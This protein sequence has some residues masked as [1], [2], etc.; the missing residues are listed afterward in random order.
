MNDDTS[1]DGFESTATRR[2]VLAGLG[3]GLALAIHGGSSSVGADSG[4]DLARFA[5]RFEGK[6]YVWAGD[7]PRSGFDCSGLTMY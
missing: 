6:P 5:L 3:A 1:I 2:V 4:K 7:S